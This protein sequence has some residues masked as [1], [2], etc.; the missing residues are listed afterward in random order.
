MSLMPGVILD[1]DGTLADNSAAHVAACVGHIYALPFECVQRLISTEESGYPASPLRQT[2][3]S[4]TM[5]R[6]ATS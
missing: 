3:R 4:T 2:S 5:L 6:Q 1:V